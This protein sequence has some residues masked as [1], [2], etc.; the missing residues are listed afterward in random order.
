MNCVAVLCFHLFLT[1]IFSTHPTIAAQS[2][3]DEQRSIP[4]Q[5]CRLT[6]LQIVKLGSNNFT[7]TIPSSLANL[8]SLNTLFLEINNLQG[9]IPPELGQLSELQSLYLFENYLTGRVPSSLSNISVLSE[10]DLDSNNLSGEIPPELGNLAQLQTLYLWGNNLKGNIP[11]SLSNCSQMVQL[12]LELNHLTGV[13]PLDFSK[14]SGLKFLSLSS[15][16]LVSCSS[17]TIPILSA[18]SNCT[19]LNKL[20]FHDNNLRGRIPEQLP[21]SSSNLF[22]GQIPS[23]LSNLQ[24]L[25]R[26]RLDNK[27]L[28]GSIPSEIGKTANLGELSV[29]HNR[30]SGDILLTIALLQQLRRLKLHH[31]RLGAYQ[32]VWGNATNWRCWTFPTINSLDNYP[33]KWLLFLIYSFIKQLEYGVGGKVLTKGDVYNYGI[34]LFEMITIKNP[35]DDMF[36][37]DLNLQEC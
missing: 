33:V 32:L 9:Q 37:G 21:S 31:N 25:Q 29:S 7:G 34:V 19:Q 16:E 8:S 35:T 2:S 18:P 30:L 36:M 10:L 4:P 23:L 11:T 20:L 3:S 13:V 22:T 28:E 24:K 1:F 26:L 17:I 5:L 12:D 27:K 15:N 14:L 6:K